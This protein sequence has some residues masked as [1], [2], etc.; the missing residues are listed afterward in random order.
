[1]EIAVGTGLGQ[2]LHSLTQIYTRLMSARATAQ[3]TQDS[4][5]LARLFW[6]QAYPLTRKAEFSLNE[7]PVMLPKALELVEALTKIGI[8]QLAV[9]VSLGRPEPNTPAPKVGD[10]HQLR[11]HRQLP[12]LQSTH[13][14]VAL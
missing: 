7:L 2:D 1:M 13:R 11:Q 10:L 14:L 4:L 9:A 6:V 8:I 5:T 3:S 12:I